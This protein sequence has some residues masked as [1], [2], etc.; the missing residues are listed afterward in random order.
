MNILRAVFAILLGACAARAEELKVVSLSAVLSDIA[1]DVGGDRVD[2]VDIVRPG[3]D[4]HGYEPTPGDIKK[5]SAARIILAGGL[6]FESYLDKLRSALGGGP[7][8]L[9]AGDVIHPIILDGDGSCG[10]T[11]GHGES[12]KIVDPHWWHSIGNVEIVARQIKGAFIAADPGGREVYEA[13]AKL[14]D[15]KL[16]ALSKWVRLQ[17]AGL[18]KN[19]RILVTSHDALGYFARDY[20]FEIHAVQGISTADQPSSQKVRT[21]IRNIKAAGVKAIFAEK[22][23]NPKVLQQITKETG[24]GFGGV[25]CTDGL[26]TADASTYDGMIRHNVTTIVNALQ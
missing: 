5:M 9:V 18:P 10:D 24:A 8:F 14:L 25:L 26:G 17:I 1:R 21:L 6:G 3:V 15:T 7:Q 4:P 2:V 13:N 23:E 16:A 19:K 11:C 20:G 12:G 22:I